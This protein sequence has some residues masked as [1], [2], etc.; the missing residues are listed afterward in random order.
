MLRPWA[1]LCGLT[2]ALFGSTGL[3]AAVDPSA[4]DRGARFGGSVVL[5]FAT[6]AIMVLRSPRLPCGAEAFAGLV[7]AAESPLSGTGST[8]APAVATYRLVE[9]A[10]PGA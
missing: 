6:P 9:A 3:V 4:S 10:P 7:A 5:A 1:G 2:V 8:E